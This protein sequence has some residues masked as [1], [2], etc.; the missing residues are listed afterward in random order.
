MPAG[1]GIG[2]V[3]DL[4]RWGYI[5]KRRMRILNGWDVGGFY[6]ET[7]VRLTNIGRLV[8]EVVRIQLID[9]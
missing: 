1:V 3:R 4:F 2:T 8:A 5:I 9:V 6:Y 7:R